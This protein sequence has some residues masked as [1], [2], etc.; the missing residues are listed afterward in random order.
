[1]P[2]IQDA[3]QALIAE[4]SVAL[5][6]GIHPLDLD[7]VLEVGYVGPRASFQIVIVDC[8]CSAML[9]IQGSGWVLRQR[10]MSISAPDKAG[11][12]PDFSVSADAALGS[13]SPTFQRDHI[14]M[15]TCRMRRR[16]ICAS[17]IL[18]AHSSRWEEA[19]FPAINAASSS[20][21]QFNV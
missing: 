8:L 15:R 16:S 20:M 1:M 21:S 19:P 5:R 14:E 18:R 11:A 13:V 7:G 4:L 6:S 10:F 2:R 12:G 3:I 9:Y 17:A